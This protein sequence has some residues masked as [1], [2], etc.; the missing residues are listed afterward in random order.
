[1][2]V[3]TLCDGGGSSGTLDGRVASSRRGLM[4]GVNAMLA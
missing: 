1:M 3:A 4:E 2:R